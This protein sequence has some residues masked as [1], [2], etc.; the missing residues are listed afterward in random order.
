MRHFQP[1]DDP[2]LL[3]RYREDMC[4]GPIG[5]WRTDLG[6]GAEVTHGTN[7]LFRVDGTGAVAH[8][9]EP[10]DPEERE[11]RWRAVGERQIVIEHDASRDTV[12]YDFYVRRGDYNIT[13]VCI[14]QIGH[15]AT[16]HFGQPGFW[17]S[18]YPLVHMRDVATETSGRDSTS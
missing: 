4:R 17:Q 3:S 5:F 10:D 11:F 13:Q 12:A 6:G 9:G 8:W 15:W 1:I 18:L 2:A 14:Y 16:Q 7:V